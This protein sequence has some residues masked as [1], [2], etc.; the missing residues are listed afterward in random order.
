MSK[1]IEQ[2]G[3]ITKDNHLFTKISELIELARKKVAA[4]VNLTM[5]HTYFEIGRMIVEEEQSGSQRAEYG[6]IVL[7]KLSKR[8]TDKFGK[9]FSEQNL[10]NM[11]QFYGM[12]SKQAFPIRQK[13]SGELQDL[14]NQS[15]NKWQIASAKSH[16]FVLSWSHYLILMRIENP[17]ERNFYEIEA[18]QQSWS[19]PQLK[20]QYHSSLYE[21]IVLSRN[22]DE[23]MKLANEGQTI[24]KL[25][26][27]LKNPL[28][29]EFLGL[30]EQ[31]SYSETDLEHAIIFKLQNFLLELGKGFLFEA[32]QKRF[33][34]DDKHFFVD[35]VFYNRLLQCYVL[36][37]IKIDELVHQD[38]GQMQM[39]VNYYDRYVK[40]DHEKPSIGILLCKKKTDALVKLTLPKDAKIYASEYSLYL[41]DKKLLQQKLAEWMA[42]FEDKLEG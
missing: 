14:D 40:L 13:A 25:E 2:S 8:L 32:R 29:L 4:A 12:Y 35:L 5:V 11:R 7:K 20:R 24:Q 22:K 1:D 30:E 9:G 19:E 3:G 26:D 16:D 37:D 10:R 42:E 28:S 27:I 33:T 38:L 36:I 17:A 6:K 41:P 18:L 34:F 23:V 39:Y 31:S 15:D 21:R